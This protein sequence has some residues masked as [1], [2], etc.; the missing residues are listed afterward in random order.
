MEPRNLA[1]LRDVSQRHK[2]IDGVKLLESKHEEL[3][4]F[5]NQLIRKYWSSTNCLAIFHS[6]IEKATLSMKG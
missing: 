4:K 1:E 6:Q 5:D 2:A 3:T